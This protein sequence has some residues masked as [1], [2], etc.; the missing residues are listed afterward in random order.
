MLIAAYCQKPMTIHRNLWLIKN[1]VSSCYRRP[2]IF[3]RVK[4]YLDYIFGKPYGSSFEVDGSS[5]QLLLR[6]QD[7][8]VDGKFQDDTVN[9]QRV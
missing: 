5:K 4:F 9:T 8:S 7:F 1:G 2:I 6:S 3:D